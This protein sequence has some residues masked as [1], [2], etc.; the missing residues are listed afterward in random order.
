MKGLDTFKTGDVAS[1]RDIFHNFI[2]L[3]PQHTLAANAVFWIAE[4]YFNEKNFDQAILKYQDLI[5]NYPQADKVPA[6]MLKQGMAF[7]TIKDTE[8]AKYVLKKLV[9]TFPKSEEAKNARVILK[10]IR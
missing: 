6:A 5:K 8:S 2:D 3:F 1:A 4:S 9:K 7:K 10:K